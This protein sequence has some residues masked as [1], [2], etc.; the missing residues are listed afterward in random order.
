MSKTTK[1][2]QA[3]KR[4]K[5]RAAKKEAQ[6]ARY[7]QY[8]DQGI[9]SKSK[10]AKAKEVGRKEVRVVR[11]SKGPCGNVGCKQCY[12]FNLAKWYARVERLRAAGL[13]D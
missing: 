9:N 8:R 12:Q 1:T 3:L 6:R 7:E 4:K 13:R 11:H 2:R 5:E 10:R